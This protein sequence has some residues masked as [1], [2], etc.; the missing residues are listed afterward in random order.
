VLGNI[1]DDQV[2]IVSEISSQTIYRPPDPLPIGVSAMIQPRRP[3]FGWSL[4]LVSAISL[5][6]TASGAGLE[7]KM[8]DGKSFAIERRPKDVDR[9]VKRP[10]VVL[11]HGVDGLSELSGPQ[12][13][14]FAEELAK[15]GYVAFVPTYFGAKDG[16][17]GKFP[18]PEKDVEARLGRVSQYG[19]RV[20]KAVEVVRGQPDADPG[21]VALVGFSLGGGLALERA[22]ASTGEI[23]AAVDFFGYIGSDSIYKDVAK[24]PPTVVFHNPKDGIVDAG[25]SRKL[26]KALDETTVTHDGHFLDDGNPLA[27]NHVFKPNDDADK[28]SRELTLKWLAKYLKP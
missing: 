10:V 15:A 21:R 6:A 20:A 17:V 13:L 2:T 8:D 22:E 23:K 28:N 16:P 19:P 18:P 26:L 11:L 24:L 25:V 27:K 1:S 9:M 4:T 3:F 14:G 7:Y 5:A 12:I